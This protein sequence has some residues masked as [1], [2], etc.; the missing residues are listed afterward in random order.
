MFWKSINRLAER[1]ALLGVIDR[2]FNRA[3]HRRDGT[4]GND[5]PLLRQLLHQLREAL[6]L[7]A[8]EQI[9]GRRH[10]V[11]EEQFRGIGGVQADLVEV[12]AAPEAVIALGL[13][14]DQR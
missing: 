7:L 1:L 8:A 10:R 9:F 5:E 11:I 12:A 4:D 2:Q 13:D 6:A 3:L 14:D